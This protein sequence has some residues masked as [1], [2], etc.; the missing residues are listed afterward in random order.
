[1]ALAHE[2]VSMIG[3]TGLAYWNPVAASEIERNLQMLTLT[4]DDRA[5]DVGCGRAELL[6]RLIERYQCHGIGVDTSAPALSIADSEAARRLPAGLL[7]L[8][9]ERFRRENFA[10]A[11]FEFVACVGATHALGN[12]KRSVR[13]LRSLLTP[14]GFLLVG[15]GYWK[16]TPAAAY[17]A[18]LDAEADD[19]GSHRGNLTLFRDEGFTVVSAHETTESAW[20]RYEDSYARNIET[21]VKKWPQDPDSSALSERIRSWRHAYLSWGHD[22]LG[23]GLYLLRPT[24]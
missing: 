1:M 14:D 21:Y 18:F 16:Q 6:L 17:L 23:F 19:M 3:H 2:K 12:L 22:T 7:E 5:L 20:Q 8:R 9:N 13:T 15:E 10:D 11:T 4:P 24:P